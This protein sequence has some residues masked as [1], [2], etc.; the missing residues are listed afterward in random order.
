MENY[1]WFNDHNFC[2]FFS[3]ESFDQAEDGQEN[4][5]YL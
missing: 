4:F 3:H 2:C 5:F 1:Y